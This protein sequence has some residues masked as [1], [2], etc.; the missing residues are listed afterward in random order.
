MILED[1]FLKPDWDGYGADPVLPVTME[2][3]E[4]F[5]NA[6]PEGVMKP[7]IGADPSGDVSLDWCHNK[8]WVFSV[9]IDSNN[10]LAYA[11]LFDGVGCHGTGKFVDGIIPEVII[12]MI[13]RI[14]DK[15]ENKDG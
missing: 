11:A 15:T 9:S 1:E 7:E 6:I 4:R 2:N 12:T 14:Q 13:K 5:I 10:N 8:H 3:A